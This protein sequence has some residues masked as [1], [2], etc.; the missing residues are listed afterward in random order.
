MLDTATL[1]QLL[2]SNDIGAIKD[3]LAELNSEEMQSKYAEAMM[4]EKHKWLQIQV[5]LHG[6]ILTVQQSTGARSVDIS[7]SYQRIAEL[8]NRLG[9]ADKAISQLHKALQH[10]PDNIHT[11][12]LLSTTHVSLSEYS[13]AID[14]Q[15]KALELMGT[16]L[17]SEGDILLGK[18]QLATIYE[19]KGEFDQAVELLRECAAACPK[20]SYLG[21]IYSRLGQIQQKLGLDNEAVETLT[22]AKNLFIKT[23]GEN[24]KKTQEV[25][26]LLDM[27]QS[28]EM[29]NSPY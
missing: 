18:A 10:D 14:V 25:A 29:T 17:V 24:H 2:S 1:K 20:E 6:R 27:A 8:W 16:K 5:M 13:H 9:E 15:K 26:Y 7:R 3:G 19:A 22:K 28:T 12:Q 21:D 11:L 23:K 4:E